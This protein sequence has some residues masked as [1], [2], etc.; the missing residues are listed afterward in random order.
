[1]AALDLACKQRIC[2]YLEE[3]KRQGDILVL[4]THDVMEMQLCDAW[5][6]L[7]DGVL[8]PF[9]YDGDIEKLAAS[10]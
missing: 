8:T 4:V 2:A 10:L 9:D 5:Y 1:M 6:L 3:R 7:K